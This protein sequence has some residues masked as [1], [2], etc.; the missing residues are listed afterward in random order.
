MKRGSLLL[1]SI[2][3]IHAAI[4]VKGQFNRDTAVAIIIST[5]FG[6]IEAL[7]YVK[8]AP[9]TCA[10]FLDYVDRVGEEGGTFYRTVTPGNQPDKKVKIE[11]IQGGFNLEHLDSTEIQPIPL[12]RTLITGLSHKDGTLSMARD[13]PDS[14]SSEF[15]ICIGDQP[16]LDFGG[17]RNPDGQGFAAFGRVIRGME[18]VKKIQQAPSRGQMLD[19]VVRILG[20]RRIITLQGSMDRLKGYYS[21]LITHYSSL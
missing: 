6:D 8:Q 16:E 11:V 4:S 17:K 20:I 1:T 18:V 13:D 5:G 9:V 14:G 12:E 3:L 2:L 10:N 15:F 19:P 21:L 7:L